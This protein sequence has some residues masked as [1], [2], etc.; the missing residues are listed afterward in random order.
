ML[1]LNANLILLLHNTK[2]VHAITVLGDQ[3]CNFHCWNEIKSHRLKLKEG[4]ESH[5]HA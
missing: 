2:K 4:P 3:T 1:H 5:V